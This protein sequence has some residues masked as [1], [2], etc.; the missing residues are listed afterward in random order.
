MLTHGEWYLQPAIGKPVLDARSR[1][2]NVSREEMHRGKNGFAGEDLRRKPATLLHS[3]V[4]V[5][6]LL[7][8]D[9]DKRAGISDDALHRPQPWRCFLFRARSRFPEAI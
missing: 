8:E 4:V 9:G 1:I 3:P 6:I 7:V 2:R 5:L